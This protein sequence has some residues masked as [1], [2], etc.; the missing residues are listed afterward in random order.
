MRRTRLPREPMLTSS[1]LQIATPEA[2]RAS[3]KPSLEGVEVD[4]LVEG[5]YRHYGYDFRDYARASLSRR[6]RAHLQDSGVRTISELQDRVLHDPSQMELLL[7]KIAVSVTGMFRDPEFFE[8]F[9]REVVP[10]LKTYPF[11]RIWHAGCAT[12]EEVYSM[13]ILLEE[14]GLLERA[15]IYATDISG[16]ALAQARRGIFSVANMQSYTRSYLAAG[17]RRAFS[18]YYTSKYGGALFEPR[19]VKNV[20]FAEHD[21]AV[22]ASFA[23]VNVV[24]CRNVLIYFN[25]EL[26]N[27]VLTLLQTSLAPLGFLCLGHKESLRFSVADSHFNRIEAHDGIYRRRH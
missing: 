20:L 5:I 25:Q 11:F 27:R 16:A 21:L 24:V 13:C 10:R 4:L 26:Q 8:S 12:G 22:D 19:L 7:S 15:R 17:G 9:R 2:E 1:A 6:L 3:P 18:D 23:E 14:E